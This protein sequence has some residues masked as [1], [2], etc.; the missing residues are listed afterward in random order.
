MLHHYGV[1][2]IWRQAK[3][4]RAWQGPC[5]NAPR[6]TSGRFFPSP[7]MQ[8]QEFNAFTFSARNA[9]VLALCHRTATFYAR[10]LMIV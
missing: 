8:R 4:G 9:C 10:S 1:P 7:S 3:S 5:P 2:G 6:R